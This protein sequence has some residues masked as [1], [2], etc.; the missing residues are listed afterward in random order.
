[1]SSVYRAIEEEETLRLRLAVTGAH[2][3]EQFG[4]TVDRIREDGF[5]IEEEI[6]S[7]LDT[8]RAVGRVIGLGSQLRGLSQTVHRASPDMLLV[9]GDREEAMATA[10]VGAY[11]N[12]PVVHLCGGDRV[13][14]NV[15][16]QVRHAVTKLA[17]LH[18][19][20]NEESYK[21]VKRLG[22]QP[23][24][25][26]NVGNPGL[27]RLRETEQLSKSALSKRLGFELPEDE[28]FILLIQHVISTEI[29]QAYDQ[30]K[31]TLEAIDDLQIRTVL[32]YPNSDAGSRRMID[33]IKEY[34]DRPYLHTSEH[35]PRVEFVNLMRHASCMLGNSS[36]G[37]MESPLLGLPVIN[38][39]NRQHGRLHAENVTFVDHDETEIRRAVK[40]SIYDEE[41]RKE[42]QNCSNPYG[43]GRSSKRIARLLAETDIDDS[44]LIKY[45]TY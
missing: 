9:L 14:G 21:R 36:A 38:V 10:L 37:I 39:G 5:A 42:A 24:R 16:D 7:L 23:H 4:H 28:P 2:L 33:A 1:M 43:D 11:T 35:I 26:H 20:T 44:L 6:Y 31:T 30:M 22:E 8:D 40:A 15:D 18:L 25:I 34:E 45:I 19:V 29:D 13:V 17:H 27:D 12:V 32:S 41:R 3:S